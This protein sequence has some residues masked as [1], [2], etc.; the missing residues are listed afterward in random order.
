MVVAQ[1]QRWPQRVG[2]VGVCAPTA[3]PL[4]SR[5]ATGTRA[6]RDSSTDSRD[7]RSITA[8]ARAPCGAGRSGSA[9]CRP[10]HCRARER[11][12]AIPVSVSRTT[13]SATS[14]VMSADATP[15]GRISTTSIPTSCRPA[16]EVPA[17]PEQIGARHSARLGRAGA[18]RERRIEHVDVDREERGH[19][20]HDRDRLLDDG[21]D[22]HVS[23]V[24][25]EEARDPVLGLPGELVLARPV[26]AQA[27]LDVA[28]AVDVPVAHE[29]VHRRPVRDLDAEDLLAGVRV[30]VEVDERDRPVLRARRPS[31]S[32]R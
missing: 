11:R 4:S 24:V 13:R 20:A 23:D 22:A 5:V 9:T 31:R 30:R 8:P 28:R 26:A 19:V 14:A 25:H 21:A 12:S 16:R 3:A 10:I 2:V 1:D 17:G 29:P 27:D 7:S 32:A 18:G 15:V 6:R